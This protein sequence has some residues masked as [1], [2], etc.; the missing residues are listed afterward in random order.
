MQQCRK[1]KV[2]ELLVCNWCME[3][4]LKC[5][6][7]PSKL[8]SYTECHKIKAKCKQ[9]GEE[10]LE[11]KY[12]QVQAEKLEVEPSG[13]KRLKKTSEERSDVIVE[14]AEVLEMGLKTITHA[15]SKQGRLLQELV[16]LE[17]D[18]VKLMQLDW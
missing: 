1:G 5:K 12:K 9:T 13:L 8:T 2:E 16:E 14:L 4:G 15:L 7:R 11:R 3:H 17:A 6:L 10:K 18:K